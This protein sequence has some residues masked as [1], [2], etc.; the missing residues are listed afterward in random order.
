MKLDHNYSLLGQWQ[1]WHL[2]VT[3][4]IG[5]RQSHAAMMTEILWTPTTQGIWTK[6]YFLQSGHN[7]AVEMGFKT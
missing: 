4:V 5:L 7:R 1:W 6:T 2:K 3:G